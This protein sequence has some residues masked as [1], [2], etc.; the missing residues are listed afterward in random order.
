MSLALW[1]SDS[2]LQAT[3]I[4]RNARSSALPQRLG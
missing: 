1:C 4:A 3:L 2:V